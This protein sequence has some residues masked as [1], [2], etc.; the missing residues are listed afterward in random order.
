MSFLV[1]LAPKGKKTPLHVDPKMPKITTNCDRES[2]I[3]AC[4]AGM[5]DLDSHMGQRQR[6]K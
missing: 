3:A 5:T 6:Q 1:N 4:L 2:V